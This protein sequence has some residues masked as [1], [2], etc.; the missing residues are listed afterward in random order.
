M[1]AD[2]VDALELFVHRAHER[3]GDTPID[4]A[5]RRPD[6]AGD[7]FD[8]AA[9]THVERDLARVSPGSPGQRVAAARQWRCSG[10]KT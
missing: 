3:D 8:V 4:V 9:M 1:L 10:T 6:R 5:E 7:R 2:S